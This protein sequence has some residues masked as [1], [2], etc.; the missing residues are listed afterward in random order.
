MVK[1][2]SSMTPD[3]AAV[4][5]LD[6]LTFLAA[7]PDAFGRFADQS[8]LDPNSVRARAQERDFLVSVLDFMLADEQFLAAFCDE[9]SGDPK[10]VHMARY[11]LGGP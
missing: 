5:A 8:G 10:A 9:G 7:D 2:S 4:L 1:T 3:R 11:V 6:A